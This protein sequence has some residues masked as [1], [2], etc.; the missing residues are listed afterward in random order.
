MKM[1]IKLLCGVLFAS[2][3]IIGCS[4][5][6]N[7]N[8]GNLEPGGPMD[9][10]YG[11]VRGYVYYNGNPVNGAYVQLFIWYTPP[12]GPDA[13]WEVG[14]ATTPTDPTNPGNYYIYPPYDLD[15]EYCR[16][17]CDYYGQVKNKYWTWSG[18]TTTY[19]KNFYFP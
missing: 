17:R 16:L 6:G 18:S 2:I 7:I 5:Q 9:T 12:D 15:G 3:L 4:D 11:E 19:V 14:N 8:P 10:Y 1:A 13:W